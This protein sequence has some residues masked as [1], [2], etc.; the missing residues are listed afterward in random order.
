MERKALVFPNSTAKSRLFCP[1]NATKR[2]DLD[3]GTDHAHPDS[4]CSTS[5]WVSSG[6]FQPAGLPKTPQIASILRS[7]CRDP[8]N[9]DNTPERPEQ[10][11]M[12]RAGIFCSVTY[13]RGP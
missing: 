3:T 8:N 10:S 9:R 12:N 6:S 5:V 4:Y 7:G 2:S 11:T 1:I 13:D